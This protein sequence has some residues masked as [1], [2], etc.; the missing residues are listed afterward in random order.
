LLISDVAS[1]LSSR[2][3]PIGNGKPGAYPAMG[4]GNHWDD[5]EIDMIMAGEMNGAANQSSSRPSMSPL[6]ADRYFSNEL[7]GFGLQENLPSREV[8]DEL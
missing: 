7:I 2:K 6:I 4:A 8:I 1:K 3:L 5:V